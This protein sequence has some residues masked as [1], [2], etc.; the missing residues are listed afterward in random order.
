M[1]ATTVD[2]DVIVIGAGHA[3]CEAALAAARMDTRVLVL[4]MNRERIAHMPCNPA[5]GG[6][7]KGHLVKEIDAL[8]GA[9]GQVADL[10]GIQFKVLN[11]SKG[12]AVRGTRTQSDM[13]QYAAAMR[14][15]LEDQPG[16]TIEETTVEALL[17]EPAPNPTGSGESG[18][19]VNGVICANGTT[20]R[21]QAIIV[22]TGTF[23]NGKIHIG[24]QRT[25]AGRMWEP[26]AK[27]LSAALAELGLQLGRL[28]TGTVPRLDPSTID[29]SELEEQKGDDPTPTFSFWGTQPQLRQI[30]CHIT[31]TNEATHQV[32]QNNLSKSAMYSGA[33]QGV[34]PRYCPS[35]EDKIVKFPDKTRHQIFLEPTGLDTHEV[36]PNGLS[37]SLPEDVQ[38]AYLRTIKGLEKVEILRPGYAVEY[39]Y[40]LPR[41]LHPTLAAKQ[42]PGLYCAGQI[43]GTS[44]YEEAAAQGLMAG[45]NA[46]LAVQ[47]KPALVLRRDEAYI[48][49]LIDDLITKG[50][51]EP[52]RMFTSR[53]EYRIFLREDNADL[54]LAEKGYRI[55]LLPEAHWQQTQA[56]KAQIDALLAAMDQQRITPTA[57]TNAALEA[58]GQP[59]I[60]T[61]TSATELLRRPEMSMVLLEQLPTLAEPLGLSK[62]PP[63][64]RQQVEIDIK[65][66]GYLERQSRQIAQF[67]K[68][69]RMVLPEDMS[70]EGISGLSRE[71][72]QKL[73]EF[74]PATLG[75]AGRISGITPAAIAVLGAYLKQTRQSGASP[76]GL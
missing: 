34:G 69:E 59:Q 74:R 35:I 65:Y 41:Q 15:Q 38:L 23:L 75:Q 2:Y 18:Q 51:D 66:Q 10:T 17:T 76:Q 16:L 33:I 63:A 50:T 12:P 1:P 71:V 49:V 48:G 37:T 14:Q 25:E 73:A 57:Q 58:L 39:D 60:R 28:K 32:I 68:L 4:T 8:G 27:G 72:Q 46:A 3:G 11:S 61:G 67:D 24:D 44:G 70:Y 43:N 13:V 21:A 42:V 22:T 30:S 52:Y 31:Y 53:A 54:R 36:Y 7:A 64:V 45:I 6:L 19:Q 20:Y 40:V 5:I 26:P 56:K 29:Y 9:M 55:G 62:I 47:K